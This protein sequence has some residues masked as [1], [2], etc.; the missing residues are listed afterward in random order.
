MGDAA[1]STDR[2]EREIMIDAPIERV[3][4][5]VSE[6]GW[7]IGD[8]DRS[9]QTVT[10]EGDLVVVEFQPYGRFGV[11]PI[12]ADAPAYVS[13][14]GNADPG[15]LPG[16]DNSTLVEFFLTEK[17]GGTLVRVV[18]SGFDTMY[19]SPEGRADALRGNTQG[20]ELQL[21]FAKRDTETPTR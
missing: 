15:E 2:I 13:F 17:D 10:R 1:R 6:P 19:P 9:K 8:G 11:L 18:E 4:S 21:G 20:W 3:W 12:A 7:W 5:L 14:R 16:E